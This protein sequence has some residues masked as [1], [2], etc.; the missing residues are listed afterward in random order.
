MSKRKLAAARQ[1]QDIEFQSS[2]PSPSSSA[3]IANAQRPI[4]VQSHPPQKDD[5]ATE[6]HARPQKKSARTTRKSKKRTLGR[7]EVSLVDI[8]PWSMDSVL[9]VGSAPSE[10]RPNPR[11]EDVPLIWKQVKDGLGQTLEGESSVRAAA[12]AGEAEFW[13]LKAEAFRKSS[14]A[15]L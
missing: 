15:G 4:P 6:E 5:V 14:I 7:P 12:M 8:P 9:R 10:E 13:R 11:E 1:A 3:S 2:D